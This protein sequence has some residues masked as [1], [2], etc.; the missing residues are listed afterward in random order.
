MCQTLPVPCEAFQAEIAEEYRQEKLKRQRAE[1]TKA[2]FI[3]A[4]YEEL[5]PVLSLPPA[6]HCPSSEPERST[7]GQDMLALPSPEAPPAKTETTGSE[8]PEGQD[9]S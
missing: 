3:D 1:M 2:G 5:Q 8:L 6:D 4:E 9:L 7:S